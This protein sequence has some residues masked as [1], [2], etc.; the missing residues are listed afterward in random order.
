ISRY[1]RSGSAILVGADASERR[2]KEGGLDRFRV[3]H[4]AT[5]GLVSERAP[6]RSALVLAH[7]D[8]DGE[9]GFLQAREIY[10][11]RLQTDLVVLSACQTAR[12][13]VVE[14]EGVQ[15]LAVA[16]LDAGARSV[17][18]SLWNVNDERTATFM[19]AFYRH[20]SAG[21]PK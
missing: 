15:S 8:G 1:M 2:V 21:E 16:F 17:V 7:S 20:L 3:L 5:H 13:S 4:F 18:A 12:G 6:Y 14:G 19:E 9:D 11:L 10:G